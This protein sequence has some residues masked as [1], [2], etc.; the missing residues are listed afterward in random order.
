[1][2]FNSLKTVKLTNPTDNGRHLILRLCVYQIIYIR[3]MPIAEHIHQTIVLP[4]I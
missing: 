1:M 4:H 2:Y 3:V